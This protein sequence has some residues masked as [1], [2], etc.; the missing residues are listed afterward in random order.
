MKSSCFNKIVPA[1]VLLIC[2]GPVFGQFTGEFA[3]P[4]SGTYTSTQTLGEWDLSVIANTA[5]VLRAEMPM[6]LEGRTN[7]S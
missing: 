6:P 4:A 5:L 1:A 7:W 2:A 3:L